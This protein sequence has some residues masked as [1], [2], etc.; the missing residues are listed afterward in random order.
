VLLTTSTSA[1]FSLITTGSS[2]VDLKEKK[3]NIMKTL[4]QGHL[5][6]GMSRDR[7][8]PAGIRTRAS[9]VGGEHFKKEPFEQLVNGYSEH[10]HMSP[11]QY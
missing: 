8:V 1:L 4:G 11:R 5:H 6:P 2:G 9:A 7:H 3:L 10:P